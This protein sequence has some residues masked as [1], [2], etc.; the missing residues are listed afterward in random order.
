MGDTRHGLELT[1]GGEILPAG[2][3]RFRLWAP[4]LD[5]VSL[6]AVPSGKSQPMARVAD[7][8]FEL[9]T[10]LVDVGG[11]YLFQLPNG[12]RVPDPAARAQRRDVHGPS[13]LIDPRAYEWKTSQWR[14]RPW[15]EAVI[16]ELHTG[17]FTPDGSFAGVEAKLDAL[18]E[19]GVTVV[20]LMP[21]NQFSG[22]RGW[23][24][25]GVL[26]YAP[27]SAY[28]GP[29]PLKQLIDAAHARGLMVFLDV[30]YNHFGPDGNYLH[31][32]APDFF[33]PRAAHAVGR[34]PSLT[35]ARRCAPSSSR[36]RFTGWRNTASTACVS[37]PS[38]RSATT[39]TRLWWRKSP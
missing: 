20:E 26:I 3:A 5:A 21:V 7:G 12:M 27:H 28:G 2:G 30:V 9:A 36:M 10:D 34:L 25:D 29:E 31:T 6:L 13:K 33:H 4:R 24:Y 16:Y 22:T 35:I 38:I 39:G 15:E 37:M 1:W 32:Y 19:L 18:A 11:C 8:W 14:G 17:T 23:G